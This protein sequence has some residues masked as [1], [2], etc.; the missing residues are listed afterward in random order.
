MKNVSFGIKS[1]E[2]VAFAGT[3]GSGKSTIVK[4]I[5]RFYD[6]SEGT[7]MIDEKNIKDLDLGVVRSSIGLV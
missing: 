5:E 6:C 7:I 2:F 3:S 1:G 4:L